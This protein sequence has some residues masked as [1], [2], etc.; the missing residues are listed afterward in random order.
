MNYFMI[1]GV[2][3]SKYV[4][5]LIVTKEANYNAQVNAAGNSV[6]DF[7]NRKRI[8]KVGIIPICCADMIELQQAID[9]FSVSISFRNPLTNELEENVACIIPEDEVEYYWIHA[10]GARYKAFSL[11]FTEL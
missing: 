10:D 2:D 1:D 8:I 5:E 6:V 4:N 7:I 9:K 3:Y 11:E